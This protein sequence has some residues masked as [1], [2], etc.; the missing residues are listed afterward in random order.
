MKL[1][2]PYSTSEKILIVDQS[3]VGLAQLELAL[4]RPSGFYIGLVVTS[5]AIV[6]IVIL[7]HVRLASSH[8]KG[9]LPKL[10]RLN[11]LD[12]IPNSLDYPWKKETKNDKTRC[13]RA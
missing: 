4:S 7:S 10:D 12:E 9:Q 8:P 13:G 2:K 3:F 11:H 1:T 5:F 6:S